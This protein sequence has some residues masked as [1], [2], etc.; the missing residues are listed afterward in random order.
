ME[1]NK[2][3]DRLIRLSLPSKG[4]LMEDSLNLL[5]SCGL[6]VYKPNPRQYEATIPNL[7]GLVILFQR[8]GDI[9]SSVRDGSVEFGI[10]GLDI[11]EEKK[12]DTDDILILHNDLKFGGCALKLAVGVQP[13]VPFTEN[14]KRR[15]GM[16]HRQTAILL[17][18]CA[19]KHA[20]RTA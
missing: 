14:L 7:P 16:H 15:K 20:C 18:V 11:L 2:S 13:R 17:H 10:T 9:V 6:K 19:L 4:R 5:K 12:G 8:P 1:N 3:T